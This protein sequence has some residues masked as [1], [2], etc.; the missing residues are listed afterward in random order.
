LAIGESQLRPPLDPRDGLAGIDRRPRRSSDSQ[1]LEPF[2]NL[3]FGPVE[4]GKEDAPA[5]LEVIS[6]YGATFE[7]EAKCRFDK[8]RRHFEQGLSERDQL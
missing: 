8:L 3:P 2:G 1:C 4:P 5:A 7:L 6:D